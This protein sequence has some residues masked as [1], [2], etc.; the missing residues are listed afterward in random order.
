[1][2]P[3]LLAYVDWRSA[4]GEKIS[5]DRF[6]AALVAG[7]EVE[8]LLGLAVYPSHYDVGWH[9]TAT[10]GSIGAAIAVAKAM[11]LPLDQ[12]VNA[13]G[14]PAVQVA[15][16]RLHFGSHAKPLGVAF[17]SRSGLQSA[18]LAHSGMNSSDR[19]NRRQARLD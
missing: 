14:L 17:A 6:I 16:M 18:I 8:C 4:R 12:L 3:A 7:I 1:V 9:I 19:F 15:G 11:N 13:I 5:G 2:A 10:V